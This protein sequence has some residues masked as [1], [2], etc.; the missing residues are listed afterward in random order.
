[1]TDQCQLRHI[2]L[3]SASTSTPPVEI[4]PYTSDLQM[5]HLKAVAMN[6]LNLHLPPLPPLAMHRL[7]QVMINRWDHLACLLILKV[8]N[9]G[10]DLLYLIVPL[11]RRL[12]RL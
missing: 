8:L 5:N 11:N 4:G 3:I 1:M 10:V 7:S 12:E 6:N 2:K 9:Y